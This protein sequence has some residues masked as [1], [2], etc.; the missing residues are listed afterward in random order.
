MSALGAFMAD[1][2]RI[3]AAIGVLWLLIKV[4]AGRPGELPDGIPRPRGAPGAPDR[5]AEAARVRA[6]MKRM[7][8]GTLMLVPATRPAFSKLGGDPE[9]PDE[10]SWPIEDTGPRAFLAQLD[11]AEVRAAGGPEWLPESG[12][13]FFFYAEG[14]GGDPDQV[15]ALH[16]T[17]RAGPPAQP[18]AGLSRKLR[19]PER[20]AGFLKMISMPSLDWLGVDVTEIDISDR[21]LDELADGPTAPFGDE[22][23][24]RIGGYPAE[25]QDER[26]PLACEHL[27][28]GLPEPLYGAEVQPAIERA[29]REWRLLL[30]IDSDP[31]LKMNWGDGG[32]LYIFIR[33]RHARAGD[34]SK[35]VSIWQTY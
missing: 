24:H 30:Q 8:T 12:R 26:M 3:A 10:L 2:I 16:S 21:E 23:Q 15:R 25:I 22:L 28:R 6:R 17:E 29:C 19:F 18:P 11:L 13:L 20:R 27:A 33:E 34:F 7:A 35:T 31:A 32:R 9:L 5:A 14:W 1:A 4:L